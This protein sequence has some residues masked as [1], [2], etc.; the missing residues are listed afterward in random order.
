M[1]LKSRLKVGAGVNLP[2]VVALGVSDSIYD[3]PQTDPLAQN[4]NITDDFQPVTPLR[5][6]G[7]HLSASN[8]KRGYN[9]DSEAGPDLT[10]SC[11][12]GN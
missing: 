10:S 4:K 3:S 11:S 5:Q 1:R 12:G 7:E 8:Y 2:P 9:S 6:R